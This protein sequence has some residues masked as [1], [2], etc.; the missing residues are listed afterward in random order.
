MGKAVGP[1][2]NSTPH[3]PSTR[4]LDRLVGNANESSVQVEGQLSRCLLDTGSQ[5][6]TMSSSFYHNRLSHIKLNNIGDLLQ[7]EAANGTTVPY[8]G[9]VEVELFFPGSLPSVIAPMIRG[10][11]LIVPDTNYNRKVPLVIGMNIIA[12]LLELGRSAVGPMFPVEGRGDTSPAWQAAYAALNGPRMRDNLGRVRTVSRR[13]IRI[14]AQQALIVNAE[15]LLPKLSM[16][17]EAVLEPNVRNIPRGLTIDPTVVSIDNQNSGGRSLPVLIQNPTSED[18]WL[19]R[20]TKLG[21]LHFCQEVRPVQLCNHVVT[22]CP[23]QSSTYNLRDRL[24]FEDSP[25]TKEDKSR[26]RELVRKYESAFS[27]SDI[28]IGH[29]RI[30]EHR[31]PLIDKEPI[32]ERYR[33]IP[34]SQYEEVRRHLQEMKEAEVIRESYSPYASPVVLVRK[35]DG[36]LRFCIDFRKLNQ[37]TIRDSY[38]LPRIDELL[39][40]MRGACWFSSLDLKAGYWQ[41]EVA[42]GDKEK[43]AFTLPPPFGLWECNRMPFGL[44][45][46]PSTFQRAMER[47]LGE[48]NHTACVVYLDDIIVFG[49]TIDEHLERLDKVI[50][51]LAEHGFKLKPEKCKLLQSKVHYLGHVLSKEGISTD[52][53]KTRAIQD[54]ETPKSVKEVRAFLGLAG[55]Y[56]KFVPSFSK[57]A[58]PLYDLLGGPRKG[59]GKSRPIPPPWNWG[60]KQEQAFADLKEKLMSPPVLQY[61]DFQQPFI[62]HTDASRVGLGA[63]LYQ[64]D[65]HGKERVIAYGSR[66]VSRGEENYPAHKLEFLALKW[67]VTEKFKDFLYGQEVQVY[68]DSNPLT[69]VLTSAKLDATGHRWLSA[70]ASYNLTLNYKAGK[71]NIDADLLSRNPPRPDPLRN[72]RQT[73]TSS[74]VTATIQ[75]VTE[76]RAPDT[77]YVEVTGH[78]GDLHLPTSPEQV[79]NSSH[80]LSEPPDWHREQ[81]LDPIIRR[82]TQILE[83]GNCPTLRQRKQ[84]HPVV[85]KL[86]REWDKLTLINGILYRKRMTLEEEVK[87]LVLPPRYYTFALGQLHN[88]NG[89]MGVDKTLDAIRRRFYWVHM[90]RDVKHHVGTCDRCLRRKGVPTSQTTAPL[91]SIKTSR[92]MELVCMDYLTVE[93]GKGGQSNIL[94]IT[95]HFT[96]Y[97]VA[98]ITPNQTARTTAKALFDNFMI[99]YG[100]PERLH[101]DQGRNFESRTIQELCKLAGIKKSRTTPYHPQ[102][103]GICERM[104]RT[105]LSMLGTLDE[106]Q[107][108][109]WKVHVP[110]LMHAY[111]CSKHGSTGFSPFYLMFGRHPRLPI[112][113]MLDLD[114]T[115]NQDGTNDDYIQRLR[116]R[117]DYAYRL[118][119][120]QNLEKQE[121]NRGKNACQ[122]REN[123][124]EIGDRVLVKNFGFKGKHKLADK[125]GKDVYVVITRPNPDIPVYE[126][127][128]E[129]GGKSS[130]CKILHRNLL[131]P[132][133]FLP[134]QAPVVSQPKKLRS[135]RSK[136]CSPQEIEEDSEEGEENGFAG[137]TEYPCH[138]NRKITKN[139]LNLT[140]TTNLGQEKNKDNLVELGQDGEKEDI[141][142]DEGEIDSE[143]SSDVVEVDS[144]VVETESSVHSPGDDKSDTPNSQ[145]EQEAASEEEEDIPHRK[146]KRSSRPPDRLVYYKSMFAQYKTSSL[147]AKI[148]PIIC[149]FVLTKTILAC[150]SLTEAMVAIAMTI[151][152]GFY[153]IINKL[154]RQ[155]LKRFF[156]FVAQALMNEIPPETSLELTNK[157]G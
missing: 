23:P 124:L 122:V 59:K 2:E 107:K 111:N 58:K 119:S 152:Y 65:D 106:E 143:A 44:C 4:L 126:V 7:V 109:N 9:Y 114:D 146:S 117:L 21:K 34:P 112:D 129:G 134:I 3:I 139:P 104:N 74:M 138:L 83:S 11:V 60:Q 25:A 78:D 96:K 77:S 95:D 113:V 157:Q 30:E 39:Q 12:E 123:K 67:A 118:A 103:N 93:D 47:C 100:F 52:P 48:L 131:L 32:R 51:R 35:K 43:T 108:K 141:Y 80:S 28:D 13:A 46:A 55:Y 10:L 20:R 41:I 63:A 8:L 75:G 132:C 142:V 140:P 155:D 115:R 49:S 81:R 24:D 19:P 27:S 26:V 97:A 133:G 73:V 15:V 88:Q 136:E 128:P 127:K 151:L 61:P 156:S 82:V 105:L 79:G 22:P 101:S 37:K 86:L 69:Y 66:S 33:R 42:E 99:P 87:Q 40:I 50:G 14:P 45:N 94:V 90:V 38:A 54:W 29:S 130:K 153:V 148:I 110:S 125:W 57:V 36:T 98:I 16:H 72:A 89:H 116:N 137:W 62:L 92:P 121:R 53:G 120:A 135:T 1:S 56:R 5:I 6:T 144:D 64:R 154:G 70:L 76:M 17:C 147:F 84:E 149:I 31:I 91:V 145:M 71:T 150:M 68:T 85:Q 102:G 18:I